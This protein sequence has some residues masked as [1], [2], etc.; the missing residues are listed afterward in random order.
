MAK[1][2]GTGCMSTALTG[3]FAGV[4]GDYFTAAAAGVAAMGIAGEIAWVKAGREGT[5]SFRAALIDA[6]SL[7]DFSTFERKAKID[8]I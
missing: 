6:V 5:G 8:E 2:T 4:T 7:L 1:V 3:A